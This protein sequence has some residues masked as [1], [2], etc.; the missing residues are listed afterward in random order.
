[1]QDQKGTHEQHKVAGMQDQSSESGSILPDISK[2]HDK[3]FKGL[4]SQ[5]AVAKEFFRV[6]LPEK[7]K[8]LVDLDT[9]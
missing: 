4:M 9:L 3:L 2:R 1:M 5:E 8:N 7:I 6:H